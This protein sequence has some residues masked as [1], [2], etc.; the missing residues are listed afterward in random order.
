MLNAKSQQTHATRISAT[1]ELT[2]FEWLRRQSNFKR[3]FQLFRY[4]KHWNSE[5][6]NWLNALWAQTNIEIFV[7]S[8]KWTK[9]K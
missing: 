9:Q 6:I 7:T 2:W 3:L 8:T 5:E 4:E 1:F